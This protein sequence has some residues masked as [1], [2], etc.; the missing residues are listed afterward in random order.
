V[1]VSGAA[2]ISVWHIWPEAGA[3]LALAAGAISIGAAA[4]G[5][6]YV[7]DIAAGGLTAVLVAAVIW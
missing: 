3:G 2:A 6:H 7:I 1:A 5:Y 4:G